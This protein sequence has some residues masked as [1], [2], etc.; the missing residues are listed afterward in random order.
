MQDHDQAEVRIQ[1]LANIDPKW[2][3]QEVEIWFEANGHSKH[4]DSESDFQRSAD[5]FNRESIEMQLLIVQ[6]VWGQM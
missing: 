5:L 4:K 2:P 3:E 1:F 6:V